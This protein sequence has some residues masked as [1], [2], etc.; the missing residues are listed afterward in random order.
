MNGC[1]IIGTMDGANVEIAEEIGQEN[2][3]IFGANVDEVERIKASLKNGKSNY[4]GSRLKKVFDAIRNGWFGDLGCMSSALYQLEQGFDHYLVCTDFYSYL[5]A[6]DKVDQ[7]YAD[8]KKWTKMAI[9]GVAYSGKFSS[10]RTIQE[11][12]SDI[13]KIE[14]VPIPK[15]SLQANARVRSFAQLLV[16]EDEEQQDH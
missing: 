15:P 14:P 5:E 4:I 2:M 3:F 7:T 16:P 1:L 12:C 13:W 8:Y 9:H 11:Y 10:D 6:Q